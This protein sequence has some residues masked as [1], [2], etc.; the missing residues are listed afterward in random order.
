MTEGW[1]ERREDSKMEG[2]EGGIKEGRKESRKDEYI[3]KY[4]F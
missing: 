1:K 2:R 3:Q 4:F